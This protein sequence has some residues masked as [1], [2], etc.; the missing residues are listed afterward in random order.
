MSQPS[1]SHY[2]PDTSSHSITRTI[3]VKLESS[4]RKRRRVETC[5]ERWQAMAERFAALM[6][7]LINDRWGD[8]RETWQKDLA[9]SEFPTD[10]IQLR[11]H[12]RQQAIH[13][14]SEAYGSWRE[15]GCP[16][17]RPRF[18]DKSYIR[19][20]HCGVEVAANDE[21][22]GLKINLE[23]HNP[24]WFGTDIGKYQAEWL[25]QAV[26]D[27]AS[28]GSAELH[29]PDGD[30]YAHL[31][32]STSVEVYEAA[33]I[34]TWVGVDL[35]EHALYATAVVRDGGIKTVEMESGQEFRHHRERLKQKRADA[36]RQQKADRISE[37]HQNYTDQVTHRV[38]R[39]IVKL[40]ER[41]QPCGIR[42]E[43][44]THY[45]KSATDPIH[46]WPYAQLQTKIAY[47][48]R[49]AGIPVESVDPSYTSETCRRC[50]TRGGAI[51]DGDKFWCNDCGYE[52]HAD[53][54][55]A[56]NVASGGVDY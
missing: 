42:L 40:A 6:P 52:V 5:I 46:D 30:V 8:V 25:Q 47:K 12:E 51:R 11:A 17:R 39:K 15:R 43:D 38:S 36:Q 29:L 13:K 24:E 23:P 28:T 4:E 44:L 7:T 3:I 1:L 37:Q 48:A 21:G 22:Y 49:E 45:R 14:V 2:E 16:G 53:V 26:E 10:E 18:G 35:G 56:I 19:I 55:G 9:L 54:N 27:D 20:C 32:V 34:D 33:E 50:G 41:R 31:T